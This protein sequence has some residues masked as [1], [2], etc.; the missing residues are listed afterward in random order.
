[1]GVNTRT[2]QRGLVAVLAGGSIVVSSMQTIVAPLLPHIPAYTGS[3][4]TAASWLLTIT[5]LTGAVFTPLLGRLGDLYGKRRVLLAS[6]G[7]LTIGALLCAIS[8]DIT[9]LIIGRAFQGAAL[10]VVPLSMSI[11]RDELKPAAVPAAVALISSTLGIGGAVALPIATFVI[12]NFDWHT[13]FWAS[14]LLGVADMVLVKRFVPPSANRAPGRFDIIGAIGLSATLVCLLIAVTQ[15][16]A[17][18]WSSPATLGLLAAALVIGIIWGFHQL[19]TPSP[20]V[21]LRVSASRPVLLTNIGATAIGFAFAANS[22]ATAQLIQEPIETGYGLG[23]SLTVT[24]LCLMPMGLAMVVLSPV[25]GRIVATRG[26]RSALTTASAILAIGYLVR[27]FTS[28]NLIAIVIGSTIVAA[29]TAIAYSALPSMIMRSVP[30][31]QTAAANGLNT[32]MRSIGQALCSAVVAAVLT[33]VTLTIDG[34]AFP[35]LWAYQL[36]FLISGAAAVA[37]L[38]VTLGLP[39]RRGT[40]GSHTDDV[41]AREH[42]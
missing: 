18:G 8:S 32:L 39:T 23:A 24:G 16:G 5:L 42:A 20:M 13:M 21:D 36:V 31:D 12:E 1:M 33:G 11:L 26:P 4:R 14:T 41:L 22:L 34:D 3:S 37:A 19:H 9:V 7:L 25:S 17:W 2:P 28:E 6:L 30:R 10:A 27:V 35:T 29:G 15:A 38:V 40:V